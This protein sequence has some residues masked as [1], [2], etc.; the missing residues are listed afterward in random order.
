[1]K[2]SRNRPFP[3]S[4]VVTLPE[5]SGIKPLDPDPPSPEFRE[6]TELLTLRIMQSMWIPPQFLG[7]AF[8]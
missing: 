5:I 4:G 7:R 2:V 3:S 6:Y 8:K 1:M